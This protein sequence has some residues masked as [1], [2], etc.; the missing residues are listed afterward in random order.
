[1]EL[2]ECELSITSSIP[3]TLT[4]PLPTHRV[5][6]PVLIY[7]ILTRVVAPEVPHGSLVVLAMG[8]VTNIVYKCRAP[9]PALQRPR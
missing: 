3:Y 5:P 7:Y 4:V 9:H 1:M 8:N 6:V 2:D